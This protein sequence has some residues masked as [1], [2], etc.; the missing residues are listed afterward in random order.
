MPDFN[1]LFNYDV[2]NTAMMEALKE[3]GE[4]FWTILTHNIKIHSFD[5]LLSI[6]IIALILITHKKHK[7]LKF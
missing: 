6:P 5:I 2:I 4:V 3:V 1:E 7:R